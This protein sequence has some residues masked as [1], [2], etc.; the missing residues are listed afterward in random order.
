MALASG[1]A[2]D[3]PAI[4]THPI[5]TEILLGEEPTKKKRKTKWVGNNHRNMPISTMS[6]AVTI[7]GDNTIKLVGAM[8]KLQCD[9]QPSISAQATGNWCDKYF[10]NI[11]LCQLWIGMV[12]L[13]L[14]TGT[15]LGFYKQW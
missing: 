6:R 2:A 5:T 13:R 11:W 10:E 12:S 4:T 3:T 9:L 7:L 1:R 8:D 15:Q 14:T